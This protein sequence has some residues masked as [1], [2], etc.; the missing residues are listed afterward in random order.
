MNQEDVQEMN[1]AQVLRLLRQNRIWSRANLSEAAGLQQATVSNIITDFISWGL[2]S[3]T[4]TIGGKKGRRSIGVTLSTE[5]FRVIAIRLERRYYRVGLFDLFGV[6]ERISEHALNPSLDA[7]EVLSKIIA[8]VKETCSLGADRKVLCVGMAIPGPYLKNEGTLALVTAFPGLAMLPIAER[9]SAALSVPTVVE[10][11]AKAAALSMW[12]SS[13][14]SEAETIAYVTVGQGVGAGI[15]V[16]GTLLRGCSGLAG[17]IGH[18]TIDYRGPACECGNR[19]CLELYCSTLA[20]RRQLKAVLRDGVES[21]AEGTPTMAAVVRAIQ[22]GDQAVISAA[23]K[24]AEYLGIG[25]V[26]VIKAYSPDLIVIGD[27]MAALGFPFLDVVRSTIAHHGIPGVAAKVRIEL[28]APDR[29]QILH[30][31]CSLAI[32]YILQKPS[33]IHGGR[34]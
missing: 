4:G 21:D 27:E 11:D 24:M 16:N 19:G 17:E 31:I 8:S 29:D 2:V 30:G 9:L 14:R 23:E 25:L 3:E 6:A 33:R 20:L 10:H 7:E 18:M 13:G 26:S 22:A 12:S 15:V 1:R 32:G 28:E 5:R 34:E